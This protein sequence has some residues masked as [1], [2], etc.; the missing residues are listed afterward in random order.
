MSDGTDPNEID[1]TYFGLSKKQLIFEVARGSYA[2]GIGTAV[3]TVLI[4]GVY[5]I[6]IELPEVVL[7]TSFLIGFGLLPIALYLYDRYHKRDLVIADLGH[8]MVRPAALLYR[9]LRNP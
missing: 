3:T 7:F 2:I 4:L 8:A 6:G 1:E 5:G 9:I